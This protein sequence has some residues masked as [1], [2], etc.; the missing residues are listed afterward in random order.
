MEKLLSRSK[1]YVP[2]IIATLVLAAYI[3]AP[4][5]D[6]FNQGIKLIVKAELVWLVLAALFVFSTYL[7]AT[8]TIQSLA[9]RP[10]SMGRTLLVQVASGFAGKLV[11]AGIGGIALNT[12]YLRVHRFTLPQASAVL[13]LTAL[14]GFVGHA[15]IILLGLLYRQ[16]ELTLG[17]TAQVPKILG[18][19][20]VIAI[21]VSALAFLNIRP[22]RPKLRRWLRDVYRS[23]R[24]Y[25]RPANVVGGFVGAI[26]VTV[27]FTAAL[28]CV[29]TSLGVSLGS[30]QVLLVY[31]AGAIGTAIT[32]T[33]GGIGGAEA[34]LAGALLAMG[35]ATPEALSIALL[36]RLIA[37]WLPI[38]PGFI[39]FQIILR[40]RYI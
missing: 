36:Y 39:C 38:M 26:G 1:Y 17:Y 3:F 37:F 18:V 34:A 19:I 35:V 11:P 33:P 21:V 31:T 16:Q 2:I 22:F 30:L 20:A 15:L 27:F 25:R 12:R 14:L 40:A 13:L 9:V 24:S 7:A 10:L 4:Q 28:W 6:S 29:A 5:Y 23:L 8:L 32:P